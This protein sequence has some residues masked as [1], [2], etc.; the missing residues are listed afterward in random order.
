MNV[1]FGAERIQ[2]TAFCECHGTSEC[3]GCI[4]GNEGECLGFGFFYGCA[5]ES[6]NLAFLEIL[7]QCICQS[8][9]ILFFY[10]HC[11]TSLS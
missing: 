8:F 11:K 1:A 6:F 9:V 3:N 10:G 5:I 2:D 7:D 4:G